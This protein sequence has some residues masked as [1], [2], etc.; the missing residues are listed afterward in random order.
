MTFNDFST[1]LMDSKSVPYKSGGDSVPNLPAI[2]VVFSRD[3]R[4]RETTAL[5]SCE[6]ALEP[7]GTIGKYTLV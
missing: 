6:L 2:P 4:P 7:T 5:T 1:S 3:Y